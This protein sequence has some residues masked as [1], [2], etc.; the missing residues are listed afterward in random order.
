MYYAS[1]YGH[2]GCC[3]GCP[4]GGCWDM[5]AWG[6]LL[7]H[8]ADPS[9][10][11]NNRVTLVKVALFG[12]RLGVVQLLPST[13]PTSR[14]PTQAHVGLTARRGQVVCPNQEPAGGIYR[15]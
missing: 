10:A 1:A 7:A 2:Q 3:G 9:I 4:G 12:G 8:G 11:A 14:P 5:H 6:W 13:A 15:P